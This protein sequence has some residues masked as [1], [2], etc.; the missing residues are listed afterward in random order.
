MS[1][2]YTLM[3][4]RSRARRLEKERK[5]IEYWDK[6]SKKMRIKHFFYCVILRKDKFKMVFLHDLKSYFPKDDRNEIRKCARKN[7]FKVCSEEILDGKSIYYFK[8]K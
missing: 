4:L 2:K 3:Y 5:I 7:K 8:E 6:V 1:Y